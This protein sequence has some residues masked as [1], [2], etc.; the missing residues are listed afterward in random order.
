MAERYCK[1]EGCRTIPAVGSTWC[2]AH[3]NVDDTAALGR[4][5]DR[6]EEL[7]AK[8]SDLREFREIEDG[9]WENWRREDLAK[10][11]ALTVQLE[12]VDKQLSASEAHEKGSVKR[13]LMVLEHKDALRRIWLLEKTKLKARVAEMEKHIAGRAFREPAARRVTIDAEGNAP[14][15]MKWPKP[16]PP[17]ATFCVVTDIGTWENLT[18]ESMR[19]LTMAS[20]RDAKPVLYAGPMSEKRGT[21]YRREK[22]IVVMSDADM[23]EP[24]DDWKEP[25]AH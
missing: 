5:N 4:R 16:K 17:L 9:N 3:S 22:G 13:A 10:I 14:P 11:A 20:A 25:D 1:H 15:S 6:V 8:L 7:K 19:E 12:A 23:V 24:P 21:M 2:L 18:E